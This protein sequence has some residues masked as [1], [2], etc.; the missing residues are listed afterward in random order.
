MAKASRVE[1]RHKDTKTR[2][3]DKQTNRR[4]E[5]REAWGSWIVDFLEYT[6][7]LY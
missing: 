7:V 2:R 4:T 3:I 6:V 1:S 5:S